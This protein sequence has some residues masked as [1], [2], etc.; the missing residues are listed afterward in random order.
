[1]NLAY[2]G[3]SE[4]APDCAECMLPLVERAERGLSLADEMLERARS[5]SIEHA[6]ELVEV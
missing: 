1:M 3:L 6:L 5:N 2:R 4:A